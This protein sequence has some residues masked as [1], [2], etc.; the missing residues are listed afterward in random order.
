MVVPD[1]AQRAHRSVPGVIPY[2]ADRRRAGR[3]GSGVCGSRY[4]RVTDHG[5]VDGCGGATGIDGDPGGLS[6]LPHP[7]GSRGIL[8]PGDCGYPQHSPGDGH[9]ST[10]P[11]PA[12]DAP[13]SDSIRARSRI[14]EG[15][16]SLPSKDREVPAPDRSGPSRRGLRVGVLEH[17]EGGGQDVDPFDVPR[18]DDD[19]LR[20]QPEVGRICPNLPLRLG[21]G[22]VPDPRIDS[23]VPRIKPRVYLWV[24]VPCK[25]PDLGPMLAVGIR[26]IEGIEVIPAVAV[27]GGESKIREIPL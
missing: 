22:G 21:V 15:L 19:I 1:P 10:F 18:P 7:R 6:G 25:I 12:G 16:L 3:A 24:A 5:R 4:P 8:L 9:E 17:R 13:G 27:A 23:L 11:W 2:R 26:P 14:P 20:E